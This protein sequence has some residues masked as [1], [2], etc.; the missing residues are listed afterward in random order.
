MTQQELVKLSRSSEAPFNHADYT[1]WL[2]N[3]IIEKIRYELWEFREEKSMSI[4]SSYAACNHILSLPS[5]K[6]I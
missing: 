6:T 4:K 2:H 5:L 3:Q 1:M